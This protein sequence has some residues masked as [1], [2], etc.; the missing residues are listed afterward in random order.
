MNERFENAVDG[1]KSR[2]STRR[3][4]LRKLGVA[5]VAV[6][7]TTFGGTGVVSADHNGSEWSDSDYSYGQFP[8][9]TLDDHYHVRDIDWVIKYKGWDDDGDEIAH[10]F[11]FG[12]VS[13]TF[14]GY[15]ESLY[16][17]MEPDAGEQLQDGSRLHVFNGDG[18]EWVNLDSTYPGFV[19]VS[20][21]TDPNWSSVIEED[22]DSISEYE[23][24]VSTEVSYN[25]G[26]ST[27]QDIFAFV[28][29]EALGSITPGLGT[30]FGL[31]NLIFDQ[32][33]DDFCGE[34]IDRGEPTSFYWDYCNSS[35]NDN[36]AP[37][38]FQHADMEL[39]VPQD[40]SDHTAYVQQEVDQETYDD[41]YDSDDS[42]QWKLTLPGY[43]SS[44]S[45]ANSTTYKE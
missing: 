37:L 18:T 6:G 24:D 17:P 8:H 27:Q 29:G 10:R 40:G 44:A 35:G 13:H 43:Y 39:K 9:S 15:K 7:T 3:S 38:G 12:M 5:T 14:I 16:D 33:D 26:S 20:D 41:Q 34:T 30:A 21:G 4:T 31:A 11:G 23:D 22:N 28:A 19:D 32:Y 2:V 42:V 36:N 1:S 25:G 45:L